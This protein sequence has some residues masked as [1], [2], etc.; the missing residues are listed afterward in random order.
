MKIESPPCLWVHLKYKISERKTKS[1]CQKIS[2]LV[3]RFCWLVCGNLKDTQNS[4]QN[5]S[6]N[7][8]VHEKRC[9]TNTRKMLAPGYELLTQVMW[10]TLETCP[11]LW[12]IMSVQQRIEDGTLITLIPQAYITKARRNGLPLHLFVF[13]SRIAFV[14]IIFPYLWSKE[15]WQMH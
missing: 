8:L 10:S 5:R 3:C 4:C 7:K 2:S 11:S 9:D 15:C 13:L 6:K 12:K 14:E 1:Y